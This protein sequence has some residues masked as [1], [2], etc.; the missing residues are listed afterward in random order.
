[1][2]PFD[3]LVLAVGAVAYPAFDHG[4]TFDRARAA[5]AFDALVR[6][7]ATGRARSVAVVVP[8]RQTWA[9]PAY[10]LAL[11]LAATVRTGAPR[12]PR[13]TI[14]TAEREP[15]GAFGRA[16][17][18]MIVAELD[19]AGVDLVSTAHP[20]VTSD[21]IVEAGAARTVAADRIVPLPLLT[22]PRLAG[23]SCD[24]D[25]FIE[26]DAEFRAGGDPDVLAIGDGTAAPYKQGG[27]AAQ[28]ADVVAATIARR[29]DAGHGPRPY[30]PVLRG[31]L[32]TDRGPR[33]LR[34]EPPGGDGECLVS[35]QCLWWPPTKVAS[36]W[37]APWLATR[38]HE[39]PPPPRV[40]ATGGI[41]RGSL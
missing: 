9:L 30:A 39:A 22:G 37:L 20:R 26:V 8:A 35:D 12:R 1:V 6:D 19:A 32:R 5:A 17:G 10:E 23:V 29:A 13:V 15:L 21:H 25:G 3:A 40:L 34:A 2:L 11:L 36:R 14:V 16:A 41:S 27:L 28:Q 7:V 33:Y 4:V 24:S 38:E 18:E 31:V